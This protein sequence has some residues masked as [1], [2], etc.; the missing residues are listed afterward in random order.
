MSD[1]TCSILPLAISPSS[2]VVSRNMWEHFC[3]T[4]MALSRLASN[5]SWNACEQ[6]IRTQLEPAKS[7]KKAEI[8]T[9]V[10]AHKLVLDIMVIQIYIAVTFDNLGSQICKSVL[11]L[12]IIGKKRCFQFAIQTKFQID[13]GWSS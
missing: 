6:Q 10:H 8:P 12:V 2:L 7:R 4:S 11:G 5:F 3:I 1:R 13:A 9:A